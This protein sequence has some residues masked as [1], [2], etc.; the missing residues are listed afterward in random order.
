MGLRWFFSSRA[1]RSNSL[2]AGFRRDRGH[3][4]FVGKR[5]HPQSTEDTGS[6]TDIL[7]D[8]VADTDILDSRSK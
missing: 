6:D 7:D 1:P 5:D 4:S 3:Q 8:T 2:G